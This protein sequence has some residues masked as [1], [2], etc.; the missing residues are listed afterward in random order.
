MGP[1]ALQ[2][3]AVETRGTAAQRRA[4]DGAAAQRLARPAHPADRDRSRPATR[5]GSPSLNDGGARGAGAVVIEEAQRLYRLVEKL[6][7]LSRLEAGAAEPRRD[8]CS[9]DEVL[10]GRADRS[11]AG[12]RFARRRPRSAARP[13]RRRPARARVR[14]RARECVATRRA[15]VWCARAGSRPRSWCGSSTAA[16]HPAARARARLRAVPRAATRRTATAAR[17]SGWRSRAGSS[18]PTAGG[19]AP[20]RCPARARRSWSSCRSSRAQA[21]G[22]A[23]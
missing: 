3:E 8:W 17:A 20:S 18:R 19:S 15:A 10:R 11:C 12:G 7:D 16:G 2:A 21:G 1:A 22:E 9:L 13:R 23:A 14:E 4:Q 6:L 5:F